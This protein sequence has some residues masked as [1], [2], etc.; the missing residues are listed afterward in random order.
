MRVPAPGGMTDPDRCVTAT[1][2]GC[3]GR[4]GRRR[5][6]DGTQTHGLLADILRRSQLDQ[7]ALDWLKPN[8]SKTEL[9]LGRCP[10]V[11]SRCDQPKPTVHKGWSTCRS[12]VCKVS[13]AA[14]PRPPT[15]PCPTPSGRVRV[16]G[17]AAHEDSFGPFLVLTAKATMS[18]SRPPRNTWLR[19][20]YSM[21]PVVGGEGMT[22]NR[23]PGSALP[24]TSDV[25][26]HGH[27]QHTLP[28]CPTR[29]PPEPGRQDSRPRSPARRS[30]LIESCRPT[31]RRRMPAPSWEPGQNPHKLPD[32]E[33]L[34]G[35]A[36]PPNASAACSPNWVS[37]TH[38][39]GETILRCK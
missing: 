23:V 12:A 8:F 26:E 35:T 17:A 16:H 11:N 2:T 24:S 29:T 19:P 39:H 3:S 7:T 32:P 21:P 13:T 4:R 38:P 10:G 14:H 30:T 28:A 20:Y 27:L 18:S 5:C 36:A 6:F 25:G 37:R 33:G 31:P 22:G 1:A 9:E 15:R 34:T